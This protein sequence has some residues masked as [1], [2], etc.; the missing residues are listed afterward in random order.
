MVVKGLLGKSLLDGVAN[1]KFFLMGV[2]QWSNPGSCSMQFYG[3]NK[4]FI[5]KIEWK[6]DFAR[7]GECFDQGRHI[8]FC[9]KMT[10]KQSTCNHKYRNKRTRKNLL[11]DFLFPVMHVDPV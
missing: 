4:Y 5:E 3:F 1:L 11:D 9:R 8:L 2:H 6:P 7:V 10:C